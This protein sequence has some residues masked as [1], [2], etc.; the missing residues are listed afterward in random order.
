[1]YYEDLIPSLEAIIPDVTDDVYIYGLRSAGLCFFKDTKIWTEPLEE[2][3][4]AAD[5]D[6]IEIDPLEE[7]AIHAVPLVTIDGE[8]L[9][10]VNRIQ[11]DEAQTRKN[12]PTVFH[13][14]GN[15]IRFGPVPSYDVKVKIYVTSVPTLTSDQVV[16]DEYMDKYSNAIVWKAASIIMMMPRRPWS[17]KSSGQYYEAMYQNEYTEARREALGY[18][19]GE[20]T[21]MG[22]QNARKRADY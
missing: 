17:D 22:M 5:R 8:P 15:V 9:D 12:K 7:A 13:K 19:Q 18:L 2:T 4:L 16:A 3:R 14:Q 6:E 1:M 10:S 20:S 21:V 11:M